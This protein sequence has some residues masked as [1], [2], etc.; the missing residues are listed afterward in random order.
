M[1]RL[2]TLAVCTTI[3]IGASTAQADCTLPGGA[4]AFANDIAQSLN[5]QRARNGLAALSHNATLSQ[6]AATHAC[7]MQVNGFFSHSG[8]DGSTAAG[9]IERAGFRPCRAAENIAYGYPT[10]GNLVAG[11]MNSPGHRRNMLLS[12]VREFGI[13]LADG[14]GGPYA[15]LVLARSC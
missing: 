14:P 9:R 12:D 15:V 7:D 1:S 8:S 6:A 3:I 11:W 4:D 13:G 2:R 5:A 10:G